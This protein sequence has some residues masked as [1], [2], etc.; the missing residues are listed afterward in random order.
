MRFI[1][2]L[3]SCCDCV[4]NFGC[5]YI[6]QRQRVHCDTSRCNQLYSSTRL[7]VKKETGGGAARLLL[8]HFAVTHHHRRVVRVIHLRHVS[9]FLLACRS[10]RS[11]RRRWV[12]EF[13]RDSFNREEYAGIFFSFRS[14]DG[15]LRRTEEGNGGGATYLIP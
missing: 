5:V 12:G 6:Y 2:C 13:S 8:S 15:A 7:R 9:S 14:L 10:V 3:F 1:L 4:L 11:R